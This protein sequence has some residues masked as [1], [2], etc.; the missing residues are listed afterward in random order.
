MAGHFRSKRDSEIHSEAIHEEYKEPE[1]VNRYWENKVK[2]WKQ[3]LVRERV[4]DNSG[5][6]LDRMRVLFWNCTGHITNYRTNVRRR[7]LKRL[8]QDKNLMEDKKRI[9]GGRGWS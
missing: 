7:M 9:I 6:L 2:E 4:A 5:S 8:M 1:E 3:L